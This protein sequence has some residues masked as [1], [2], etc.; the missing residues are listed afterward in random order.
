MACYILLGLVQNGL[1]PVIL[2]LAARPGP[3]AGLTYAAFAAAGMAAPFIGAWS[4]RH[5]R[6]RVTLAAG[7][8]LAGLALLAHRLP[9]GLAQH[10]ATAALVGF[11]VSAASTVATMFIVEVVPEALWDAQIGALQAC[12]GGGQLVGLLLAGVFGLRH[13][14]DTFLLGAAALFVAAPVAVA[15]APDPVVK[16]ERPTLVPRPARSGDGVPFGPQRS[17]QRVTWRALAGLGHSPL[18]WFLA[19]WLVSYTATNGLSVMFAVAMVRDYH[20]DATYPTTACAL[21]V[22]CSLLLYRVVGRWDTRYGPWRV[23]TAGLAARAVLV[24]GMVALTAAHTGATMVPI[25]ACFGATQIIWP[26]L[27]VAST[28]LSITLSPAR[29]A[30]SVGLLNAGTSLGATIGGVLGGALLRAGFAWLCATVLA[31]LVVAILLA[32]HPKIRLDPG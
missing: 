20:V 18:A 14:G 26:L 7:L 31:A 12:I 29:R 17:L 11:G 15:F 6:H 27:S 25:L 5:R 4:D 2:P 3:T 30:E 19:A 9:G 8:S 16:V 32:W 10:M 24:A 22:G 21:G 13:V 23:L 28:R 1:M